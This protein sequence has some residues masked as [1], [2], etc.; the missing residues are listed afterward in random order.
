MTEETFGPTLTV[1]RVRDAD[2]AVDRANASAYGLGSAVF[3]RAR[4]HGAGP[5]ACARA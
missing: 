1:A 4:G 3:S 5:P 2:E